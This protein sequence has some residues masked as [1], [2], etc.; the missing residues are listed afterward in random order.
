MDDIENDAENED[1]EDDT[2]SD[3]DDGHP[4]INIG[5]QLDLEM[6]MVEVFR[7]RVHPDREVE[8]NDT[9]SSEDE[10]DQLEG[11]HNQE[12]DF[13]H[14]ELPSRHTVRHSNSSLEPQS[15]LQIAPLISAVFGRN[16]RGFWTNDLR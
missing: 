12:E 13:D 11:S 3:E 16:K 7:R 14:H 8:E 4:R 5:N 15:C 9:S 6:A 10:T 1:Y 2:T